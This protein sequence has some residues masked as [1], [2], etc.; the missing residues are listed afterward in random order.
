MPETSAFESAGPL[1]AWARGVAAT[2]QLTTKS[3]SDPGCR[4]SGSRRIVPHPSN[5]CG[6]E[7]RLFA[8][9]ALRG[10]SYQS[11]YFIATRHRGGRESFAPAL[12][13]A[14]ALVDERRTRDDVLVVVA[15]GDA[16]AH[17]LDGASLVG[18]PIA[19]QKRSRVDRGETAHAYA[20]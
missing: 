14:L 10:D 1:A 4:R 12:L 11:S 18:R 9:A 7:T 15:L 16:G 17:V 2:R 20:G 13:V 3:A 6:A 5:L 19:K 8:G